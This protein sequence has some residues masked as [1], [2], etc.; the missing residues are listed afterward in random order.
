ML[1]RFWNHR[2]N[3]APRRWCVLVL[4]RPAENIQMGRRQSLMAPRS[5]AWLL[6]AFI[7][8]VPACGGGSGAPA[9]RDQEPLPSFAPATVSVVPPA[10]AT[11]SAPVPCTA[12]RVFDDERRFAAELS[13]P[14][15]L[16][17]QA[18][19]GDYL[20]V[21]SSSRGSSIRV[22]TPGENRYVISPDD[23]PYGPRGCATDPSFSLELSVVTPSHPT[24]SAT[25]LL[26]CSPGDSPTN[27]PAGAGREG[28][29]QTTTGA[30]GRVCLSWP[31]RPADEAAYRVEITY[32]RIGRVYAYLLPGRATAFLVPAEA[33][34]ELSESNERCLERKDVSVSL[35]ALSA[36]GSALGG[37]GF[38]IVAECR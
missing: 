13:K 4:T 2:T 15:C 26:A 22:L 23:S 21:K 29:L 3:S 5:R 33:G 10:E 19:D 38:S 17:L 12:A 7:A 14:V 20:V 16:V 35:I 25:V 1:E 6:A 31:G 27:C 11:V 9:R 36:D 28:R 32:G 24:P 30:A 37:D 18:R 8:I 34:P